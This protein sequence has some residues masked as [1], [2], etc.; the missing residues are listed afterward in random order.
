MNQQNLASDIWNI[1]DTLRGDFPQIEPHRPPTTL[2]LDAH[3]DAAG[4][5]AIRPARLGQ[6][7]GGVFVNEFGDLLAQVC[8]WCDN[9][10]LMAQNSGKR[11]ACNACSSGGKN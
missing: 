8:Y 1:A 4:H 6:G 11:S 7:D 9:L 3:S 5:G 10:M 2:P